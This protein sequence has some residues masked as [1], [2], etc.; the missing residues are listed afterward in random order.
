MPAAGAVPPPARDSA[1]ARALC[2][3]AAQGCLQTHHNPDVPKL[4]SEDCLNVNV[5]APADLANSS[6]PVMIFFHGGG[7]MEGSNQGPFGLYDGA[8]MQKRG[9][10]VVTANYRLHIPGFL[11]TS[12]MSARGNYGLQDQR[13][14][15][16]F[17][18]RNARAFGG[19]PDRVT[20]W[21]ESAGAMSVGLHLASPAS[22][23]LFHAAILESNPLGMNYR[24]AE[25]VEVLGKSFA[26]ALGCDLGDLAC[27][28]SKSTDELLKAMHA[29]EP[30]L[31]FVI[32]NFPHFLDGF[33]E[34]EPVLDDPESDAD[35]VPGQVL[36]AIKS[37]KWNKVPMLIGTNTNEGATFIYAALGKPFSPLLYDAAMFAIFGTN[38]AAVLDKYRVG[39]APPLNLSGDARPVF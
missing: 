11:V 19:D 10:V 16:R 12:D 27:L 36:A 30:P 29:S 6:L 21:G 1:H 7:F 8:V 35:D 26:G 24:K 38:G 32:A 2:S 34:W 4:Q 33:L 14:A 37:G 15:M 25:R 23:G 20:I 13:E 17:V 28:R 3:L 5:Y 22:K 18:Q 39:V 9:V 31:D